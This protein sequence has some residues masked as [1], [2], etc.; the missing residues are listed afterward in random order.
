MGDCRRAHTL[1]RQRTDLGVFSWLPSRMRA[2][3]VRLQGSVVRGIQGRFRQKIELL[4]RLRV[5]LC[6]EC[7]VVDELDTFN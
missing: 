2:G 1:G 6:V 5:R 7:T 3:E 4:V